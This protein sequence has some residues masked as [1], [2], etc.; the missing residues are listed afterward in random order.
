MQQLRK[1]NLVNISEVYLNICNKDNILEIGKI[2]NKYMERFY[3]IIIEHIHL[4]KKN[5]Q[6]L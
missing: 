4:L 3:I 6:Y 2:V 1:R 5:H